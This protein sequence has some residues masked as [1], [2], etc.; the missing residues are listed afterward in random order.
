MA[1]LR[2]TNLKGR[3][4]NIAPNLPD[5]AN[6]TGVLTATSFVGSGSG[7]TGVASTDNIVTGTAATFTKQVDIDNLGVTGITTTGIATIKTSVVG[8]S[9]ATLSVDGLQTAGVVTATTFTGS[10]ANMTSIPAVHLTGA[11]PSASL[12]NVDLTSIRSD[13]AKLALQISVETNRASFNLNDSF[14]DQFENSNGIGTYTNATWDSSEYWCTLGTVDDSDLVELWTDWGSGDTTGV[15]MTG[16]MGRGTIVETSNAGQTRVSAAGKFETKNLLSSAGTWNS[17]NEGF[18][19]T[20]DS[21]WNFGTGA[22]TYEAWVK[23]GDTSWSGAHNYIFDF[24]TD[25]DNAHRWTMAGQSGGTSYNGDV[26]TAGGWNWNTDIGAYWS[27]V[28]IVRD[29]S[30]NGAVFIDGNRMNTGTESSGTTN[31]FHTGNNMNIAERHNGV[32]SAYILFD[33]MR[34]SSVARYD[35]TQTTYTVPTAGWST[36][37]SSSNATGSIVSIANTASSAQTKVSGVMLYTDSTGTA[38]LGTDLI[39]SFTCDGGSNWAAA[40]SY[41]TGSAFSSGVKTVYLGET[42]CTSGTDVRY[43]VE[44]ANQADGSKVTHLKGMAINY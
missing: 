8:G 31:N 25:G 7:L 28:A 29:T 44:W 4:A 21:N 23:T 11:V 14:I 20:G 34:W 5:G 9:A 22:F 12:T 36:S 19:M 17:N 6:V 26:V 10:A 3:T 13:I 1:T 27:H 40:A 41:T 24:D 37:T 43:K 16:S 38:T 15:T 35:P 42:T 18:E 39:V 30:G 33:Q 2:V 32:G